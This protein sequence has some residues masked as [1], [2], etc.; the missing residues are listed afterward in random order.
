M[1][2][3]NIAYTK[4]IP[5]Q[6]AEECKLNVSGL[7]TKKIVRYTLYGTTGYLVKGDTFLRCSTNI[8]ESDGYSD[9]INIRN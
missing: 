6:Q 9:K 1:D 7:P 2:L 5:L 3:Q 4:I 8:V